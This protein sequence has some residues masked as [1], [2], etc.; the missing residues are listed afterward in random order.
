MKKSIIAWISVIM[1][2]VF[3]VTS[4]MAIEV[5]KEDKVA[6]VSLDEVANQIERTIPNAI[7]GGIYL[8]EEGNLY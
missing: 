7:F 5:I 6:G 3:T 1:L 4:V 8:D 2:A